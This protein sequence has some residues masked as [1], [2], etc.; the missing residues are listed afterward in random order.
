MLR[1]A[2]SA[3]S[4]YMEECG[5]KAADQTDPDAEFLTLLSRHESA[6]AACVH[7]LVPVWQDA[8]DVLQETRVTLWRKFREFQRGSDFPAWGRTVARY[9]ARTHLR[10]NG[11]ARR[12]L[13]DDVSERLF[14]TMS[15]PLSEVDRRQRALA[16]CTEKLNGTERDLLRRFYAEGTKIAQIAADVG[17]SLQGTYM[18]LSRIRRALMECVEMRLRQEE[19]P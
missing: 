7:A 3:A 15:R 16:D 17:R 18:A 4:A 9:I 5:G 6:L 19:S 14:E 1:S 11:S 13:R 8:E 10:R 2:L 12:V